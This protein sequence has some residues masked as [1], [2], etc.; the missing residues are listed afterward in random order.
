MLVVVAALHVRSRRRAPGGDEPWLPLE[1]RGAELAYAEQRFESQRHGLVARLD[2]AY[3]LG[4]TLYLVELKTRGAYRLGG[5]LYLVELKTRGCH[6]ARV[7]D[8]IE[9]SAQRIVLQERTGEAVSRVAYVAVQ[10]DGQGAPR[11]VRVR[12]FGEAQVLAMRRRLLEVR[13]SCGRA[14]E[15][16]R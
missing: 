13:A 15:P 5:T 1:L 8:V 3:R 16:A 14:P 7:S 10:K 6:E 4:G 2:R 11:P 12:L 9:L